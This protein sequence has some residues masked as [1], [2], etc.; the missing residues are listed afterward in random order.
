MN[1]VRVY[2]PQRGSQAQAYV[3]AC[4]AAYIVPQRETLHG[5]TQRT[6][7]RQLEDENKMRPDERAEKT[8]DV[9]MWRHPAQSAQLGMKGRSARSRWY[10]RRVGLLGNQRSV[11]ETLDS[12]MARRH[13]RT[14]VRARAYRRIYTYERARIIERIRP[15]P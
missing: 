2:V 9:L 3:R 6:K 4:G 15:A 1:T 7:L 11:P 10:R 8:D 13:I 12:Y 14:R 5:P